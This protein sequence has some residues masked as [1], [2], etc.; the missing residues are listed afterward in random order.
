MTQST[1]P[2]DASGDRSIASSVDHPP[3]Q[4]LDLK[5]GELVRVREAS[6]IFA[7]LDDTGEPRRHA[8]HARD[9]PV[10]RPHLP[11]FERADKTCAGDGVVRRMHNAVHLASV[12]CDGAL[13]A[14]ARPPA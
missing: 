1:A 10:L 9:A 5:P 7:T 13:T 4:E 3:Q 12:R 11:R 14:A 8:V 2:T 6:E